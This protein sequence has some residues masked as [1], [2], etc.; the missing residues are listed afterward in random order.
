M[1]KLAGQKDEGFKLADRYLWAQALAK[2]DTINRDAVNL[3][4]PMQWDACS[5][6]F[7]DAAER[8]LRKINGSVV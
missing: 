5:Q 6:F 2:V 8:T 4:R 3:L 7:Q 1:E